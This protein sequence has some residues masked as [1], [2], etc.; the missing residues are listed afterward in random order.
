M[1]R[2]TSR[3]A[4]VAVTILVIENHGQ[5]ICSGCA[6]GTNPKR[7]YGRWASRVVGSLEDLA[8]RRAFVVGKPEPIMFEIACEV[9]DGCE[10]VGVVGDHLI[11]DIAGAKR[12]GLRT[13]LVLTA[14]TSRADLERA[15]ILP[16]LVLQSLA[17]LLG[18][19]R[20]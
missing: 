14:T 8:S 9:L 5:T 15:V 11:A 4:V 12:A 17:E 6:S 10:R 7:A 20:R 2:S 1:P 19:M 16:D 13:V 3:I 18:A